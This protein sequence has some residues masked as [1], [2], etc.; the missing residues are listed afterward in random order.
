MAIEVKMP[1]LGL[2]MVDGRVVEWKKKEGEVVEQGE[3][4]C[5]IETE[6]ATYEIEAPESGILAKI[7]AREDTTVP[8]GELLAYILQ[9]GEELLRSWLRFLKLPRKRRK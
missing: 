8:V 3:I 5:V 1:K 6:K 2:T 9:P 7:V 4:V